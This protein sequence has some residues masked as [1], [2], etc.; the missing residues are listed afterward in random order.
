MTTLTTLVKREPVPGTTDSF[1]E[2]H[3]LNEDYFVQRQ[4][5]KGMDVA[6]GPFSEEEAYSAFNDYIEKSSE[7]KRTH[8]HLAYSR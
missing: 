8:L 7:M 5:S 2:I 6:D 4:H 3:K 1:L